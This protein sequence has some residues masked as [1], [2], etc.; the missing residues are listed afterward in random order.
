MSAVPSGEKQP[1]RACFLD[2]FESGNFADAEV[3]CGDQTW[4]VHRAIVCT[5][6]TWMEKAL[7][8]GFQLSPF[9]EAKT[10]II[11]IEEN[12]P[13]MV[14]VALKYI[15]MGAGLDIVAEADKASRTPRFLHFCASLIKT[16]DYL[17]LDSLKSNTEAAVGR[18]CDEVMKKLCTWS[19]KAV[20]FFS[21]TS[22]SSSGSSC[23]SSTDTSDDT[24]T[25]SDNSKYINV[26]ITLPPKK[27]NLTV[28]GTNLAPLDPKRINIAVLRTDL[29]LAIPLA[30]AGR[31]VFLKKVLLEFVWVGRLFLMD[32]MDDFL[33][34]LIK[35]SPEA[36][37]DLFTVY[38]NTAWRREAA[39]APQIRSVGKHMER[40][41]SAVQKC[42]KCGQ[43]ISH[44]NKGQV[45]CPFSQNTD[46]DTT[47]VWCLKCSN[48]D[49]IPWR[50]RTRKQS[51]SKLLQDRKWQS[52]KHIGQASRHYQVAAELRRLVDR[53]N[54]TVG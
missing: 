38:A 23:E 29:S 26:R 51:A 45:Y 13:A 42:P 27:N 46:H 25:D 3:R 40:A 9:K 41:R 6:S 43:R 21:P 48:I 14:G 36:I 11:T 28:L 49:G 1:N 20:S 22:R 44:C 53:R 31:L 33:P 24:S 2:L 32:D 50:A 30:Y 12:E 5:R 4:K 7:A 8:G 16:A 52:D 10:G 39:W 37:Q 47:R 17:A 35:S 34:E 18:Y 54:A 15:Y 19:G